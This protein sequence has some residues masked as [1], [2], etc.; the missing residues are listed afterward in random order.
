MFS[1]SVS[2]PHICVFVN[3]FVEINCC[4]GQEF[5]FGRLYI[6]NV[7]MR[8]L[9]SVHF[10]DLIRETASWWDCAMQSMKHLWK[11]INL[12]LAGISFDVISCFFCVLFISQIVMFCPKRNALEQYIL[13]VLTYKLFRSY[14]QKTYICIYSGLP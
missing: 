10:L 9:C 4:G 13:S 6:E 5:W 1:V 3:D 11:I 7:R 14:V 12:C 8:S 2:S